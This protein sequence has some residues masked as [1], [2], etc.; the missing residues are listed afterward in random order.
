MIVDWSCGQRTINKSIA[1]SVRLFRR[2]TSM[3]KAD[4]S[5][6]GKPR[7]PHMHRKIHVDHRAFW[8]FTCL[9]FLGTRSRLVP[10]VAFLFW[11]WWSFM[12]VV[13]PSWLGLPHCCRCCCFCSPFSDRT[14]N[15]TSF[16]SSWMI[17]VLM[18]SECT[19]AV[20]RRPSRTNWHCLA[21]IWTTTTL[22]RGAHKPGSHLWQDGT[23]MRPGTT[24]PL[25]EPIQ[26][27]WAWTTRPF[28]NFWRRQDT[29]PTQSESGTLGTQCSKSYSW[30]KTPT[31]V[32]CSTLQQRETDN[33]PILL[34]LSSSL[35]CTSCNNLLHISQRAHT[36][37]SRFWFIFWILWTRGY[38]LLWLYR[39]RWRVVSILL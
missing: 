27:G 17:W 1:S 9:T 35:L 3:C 6:F 26:A 28:R 11:L 8:I 4:F 16:S 19:G 10:N 34:H 31:N 30:G 18:I 2:A 7:A 33:I 14:R 15:P 39:Q 37:L 23:L 32:L 5:K 29:Q 25:P 12:L 38:W 22:L 36:N 21:P 24:T 20:Y 13:W